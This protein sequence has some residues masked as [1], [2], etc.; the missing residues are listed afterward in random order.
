MYVSHVAFGL[1][2]RQ[3]GLAFG[4]DRTTAAHACRVVEMR[5]EDR[6]FD[7]WVLALEKALK[8]VP[9]MDGCERLAHWADPA[10]VSSD[11]AFRG[12]IRP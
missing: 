8:T 4:R 12:E 11:R 5:R 9:F 7:A 3:V 10:S 6:S 1:T 2:H